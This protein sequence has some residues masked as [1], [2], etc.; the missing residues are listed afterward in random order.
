M[1]K[2]ILG[3][4]LVWFLIVGIY[5][6]NK[7]L[8][9]AVSYASPSYNISADEVHFLEDRT[10]L[11][12]DG[13]R[14]SEQEIFDE[15][16]S[17]IDGAE[18]YILIDLFLYNDFLG[19]ETSAYRALSSELTDALL[20]K[21]AENPNITIQVITDPINIVYGGLVD[22]DFDALEAA[23]IPVIVTNLKPLRD[24]NPIYS[25]TW[26]TGLQWFGNSTKTGWL[27]NPFAVDAPK[28]SLRSYLIMLNYKANHRKVVLAD[29][30]DGE[31]VGMATLVTS[32]NPH[33]GS[34]AHSNT[35]LRVDSEIWRDVITTESAVAEFSDH[36][37][38]Y[39]PEE[40]INAVTNAEGQGVAVQLLTERAIEEKALEMIAGAKMGDSLD[41]AMFYL[42]DRDI[43]KALKRA[44]EREV[45]IRLLLD[46]NKDAFGRQKDGKPNRQVAHEL[47]KHT[48]GNTSIRWCSTHGE[49]CHSKLLM[50][51]SGEE[52]QL[53]LGSANF[54]RRNLDDYNLETNVY[55]AGRAS[56]AVFRKAQTFFDDTWSNEAGREYSMDYPEYDNDSWLKTI[57]Y[58]VKEFTG[59]SRW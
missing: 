49:Q 29:F 41:M 17:M 18:H 2:K 57:S 51:S 36:P 38:V 55:T 54:T 53:L 52:K 6:T 23:G 48:K 44:D 46:P 8:P 4:L 16:A 58:R 34:S 1:C 9:D 5:H 28:L 15:V 22:E 14:E 43:V 33:D 7:S 39:P 3:A 27:P 40:L 12:E 42:A 10:F 37:F 30:R 50:I 11:N 25:S 21:K 35:A 56:E 45:A 47:I 13:E 26:R 19:T 24:S 32:A 59:L 20:R 31:R